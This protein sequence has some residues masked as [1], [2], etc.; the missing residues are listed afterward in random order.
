MRR[1]IFCALFWAV[2]CAPPPIQVEKHV[3]EAAPTLDAADICREGLC[4]LPVWDERTAAVLPEPS[5][6]EIE[7]MIKEIKI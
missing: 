7:K 4:V 3:L 1:S 2:G 6:R 5:P